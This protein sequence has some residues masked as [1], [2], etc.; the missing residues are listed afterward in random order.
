M[1][2]NFLITDGNVSSQRALG[3]QAAVTRRDDKIVASFNGR[4]IVST[5][6]TSSGFSAEVNHIVLGGNTTGLYGDMTIK[7]IVIYPAQDDA[8]LPGLS[9]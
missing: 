6:T 9:I 5:S 4:S 2:P 1:T 7:K 3:A 8:D